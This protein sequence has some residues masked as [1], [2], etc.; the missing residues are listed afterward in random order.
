MIAISTSIT[1]STSPAS[2]SSFPSPYEFT[3][4]CPPRLPPSLSTKY[5]KDVPGVGVSEQQWSDL[6]EGKSIWAWEGDG[7]NRGRGKGKGVQVEAASLGEPT[8]LWQIKVYEAII[9]SLSYNSR[10]GI[11]RLRYTAPR[12]HLNTTTLFLCHLCHALPVTKCETIVCLRTSQHS[13]SPLPPPSQRFHPLLQSSL[14]RAVR[15]ERRRFSQP[16]A[17]CFISHPL[18]RNIESRGGGIVEKWPWWIAERIARARPQACACSVQMINKFRHH[19]TPWGSSPTHHKK[20]LAW[21]GRDGEWWKPAIVIRDEGCGLEE[22]AKTGWTCEQYSSR[23]A[24]QVVPISV[25]HC[26]LGNGTYTCERYLQ[27]GDKRVRPMP[28][29]HQKWTFLNKQFS[30]LLI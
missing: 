28:F 9:I 22:K 19:T 26:Y 8:N 20:S 3:V 23:K 12:R 27:Y 24:D 4:C 18:K 15:K 5:P 6:R 11:G 17:P 30:T 25:A 1:P 10:C 7:A 16:T 2:P 13:L 29:L 21:F 14:Q